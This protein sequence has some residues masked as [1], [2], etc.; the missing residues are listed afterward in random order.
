MLTSN[1]HYPPWNMPVSSIL[2]RRDSESVITES[3]TQM[4]NSIWEFVM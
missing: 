1:V 2:I 3:H 4:S